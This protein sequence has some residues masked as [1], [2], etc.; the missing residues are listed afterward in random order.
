[1][2]GGNLIG[3]L[4]AIAISA[5]VI[6]GCGYGIPGLGLPA[7]SRPVLELHQPTYA[8][9]AKFAPGGVDSSSAVDSTAGIPLLCGGSPPSQLKG[10]TVVS[11]PNSLSQ[12]EV[13]SYHFANANDAGAFFDTL[14]AQVPQV[15]QGTCRTAAEHGGLFSAVSLIAFGGSPDVEASG[16]TV[17]P[18]GTFAGAYQYNVIQYLLDAPDV[19]LIRLDRQLEY[20]DVG[21]EDA[22]DR[23][24]NNGH[25]LHTNTG[26]HSL[27]PSTVSGVLQRGQYACC[28]VQE[29]PGGTIGQFAETVSMTCPELV[30]SGTPY[31]IAIENQLP[32]VQPS[33]IVT[34]STSGQA[35]L[36]PWGAQLTAKVDTFTTASFGCQ[37]P[38]AQTAEYANVYSVTSP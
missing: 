36:I 22:V 32:N 29:A 27:H 23:A 7:P 34:F 35:S 18:S 11:V 6:A 21:F 8:E 13:L 2:G 1:M 33:G 30:I 25:S 10:A 26:G 24:I 20:A 9:L 17:Y 38:R 3:R 12:L 5:L 4:I 14:R 28:P 16:T 19:Y 37:E 15:R 31:T